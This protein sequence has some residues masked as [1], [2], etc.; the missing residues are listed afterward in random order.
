MNLDLYSFS[1][2]NRYAGKWVLLDYLGIFFAEYLVYILAAALIVS[3]YVL[4]NAE[5]LLAPVLAGGFSRFI[6]NESIY[7]FYKRKRPLEVIGAHQLIKKSNHPSFPSGHTSF[8]FAV[9]F[10][11]LFFSISLGVAFIILSLLVGM[12]RIF[13][14]V[15]WPSDILGGLASG[16][17]SSLIV[18]FYLLPWIL[19]SL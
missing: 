3:A 6:I 18:Y 10:A 12:G 2:I 15:H 7:F 9:S 17:V 13:V 11:L 19:F 5:V 4:N 16:A 1:L 14:G 8:L